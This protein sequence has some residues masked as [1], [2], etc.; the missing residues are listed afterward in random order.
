M[1]GL[2][3]PRVL[4]GG[5]DDDPPPVPAKPISVS[6]PH[7]SRPA[8][9]SSAPR[10]TFLDSDTEHRGRSEGQQEERR[11]KTK[12]SRSLSGIFSRSSEHLSVPGQADSTVDT[13]RET[14]KPSTP[15]IQSSDTGRMSNVLSWFGMKKSSR[16]RNTVSKQEG[17]EQ[18]GPTSSVEGKTAIDKE[19]PQVPPVPTPP[20]TTEARAPNL[21]RPPR[22]RGLT[23][24]THN[25]PPGTPRPTVISGS[26]PIAVPLRASQ[27]YGS[28]SSSSIPMGPPSVVSGRS[29]WVAS[30][31]AEEE[32]IIFSPPSVPW[33][34]S[35]VASTPASGNASPVSIMPEIVEGVPS[36]PSFPKGGSA[37]SGN[38]A[39]LRAQPDGRSR[40]WSDA[41]HPSPSL[42][43]PAPPTSL[44]SPGRPKLGPRSN[45]GNSA[46]IDR[47]KGVFAKS[48]SAR[49]RSRSRSLLPGDEQEHVDE[50]GGLSMKASKG[51]PSTAGSA[52]TA[53]SYRAPNATLLDLHGADKRIFL[54]ESPARSAR[55]SFS[56]SGQTKSSAHSARTEPTHPQTA[57]PGRGS[58]DAAMPPSAIA[59]ASKTRARASTVS[60]TASSPPSSFAPPSPIFRALGATPP[61][62][63]PSAISRISGSRR[64]STPS[65]P[66]GGSLFPLPPR[67]SGGSSVPALSADEGHSASGQSILLS[68][69][70]S[71]R[72]STTSL[73]GR[74]EG[75]LK[76]VSKVEE[77]QTVVQ[78]LDKV[79]Q[80]V[81]SG[82]IAG[83]LASRSA[84]LHSLAAVNRGACS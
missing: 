8:S 10:I 25:T 77:G 67:S 9:P 64:G 44:E 84:S 20:P 13:P 79:Q 31:A 7:P 32:E 68:P 33:V 70:T 66:K 28:S 42:A 24:S 3:L 16:R 72:P 61:R 41:P 45:S 76:Q 35:P 18:D 50:F 49:N 29:S 11:L 82:D 40:A 26:A 14:E 23:V 81:G 75:L 46:I 57:V 37:S 55:N 36:I 78:W 83:V 56:G 54:D 73:T 48:T 80:L 5:D 27:S 15:E 2:G 47:M 19:A 12:R 59:Q 17:Q 63:R 69:G 38:I 6:S 51:R 4:R 71:P 21:G 65:S 39:S 43:P 74:N 52:H 1:I 22:S 53:R 58:M 62:R 34:D 60:F 30:P